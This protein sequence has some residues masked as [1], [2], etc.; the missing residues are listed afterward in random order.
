MR[1]RGLLQATAAAA[2]L[3]SIAVVGAVVVAPEA[4]APA[5]AATAAP[6]LPAHDDVRTAMRRVAD[7]YTPT[8]AKTTM[9]PNGWNWSTYADGL[10]AASTATGESRYRTGLQAWARA[11]QWSL[12]TAPEELDP[13]SLKAARV[14]LALH[15]LDPSAPVDAVDARLAAN[16]AGQPDSAY[17]W[18]DALFM[19]LPVWAASGRPEDLAKM[20]A[21]YRWTRDDG[22]TAACAGKPRGLYDPAERLW[23]RD[24]SYLGVKD[25]RGSK[26][27]WSRGNGWVLAGLAEVLAELPADDPRA[28]PY[29]EMFRA[30][31]ARIAGLQGADG[32]WRPSLVD[33]SLIPT[34][35]T[36]GTALF[37]FALASGVRSGVLDRATY[38]PVIAK[39]WRGLSTVSVH[40]NGYVSN[41]QG[42]GGAPRPP[43]VTGKPSTVDA[44]HKQSPPFCVGAVLLAASEL[45]VLTRP[46][47]R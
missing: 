37:T 46:A 45:A 28:A 20:D 39:A 30:M 24:C 35:E 33:S 17:D 15:E 6:R 18:I 1:G 25:A 11:G 27:F 26:I 22:L 34:P 10:L 32:L 21:L 42:V 12:S 4:A 19:G 44:L 40:S 43:S 41:C 7:A 31:A 8:L 16:L 29:R 14:Y 5:S 38:L 13:N 47:A 23:Y 9:R 3:A 36:S 2:A